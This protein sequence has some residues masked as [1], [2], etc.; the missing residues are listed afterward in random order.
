[1]NHKNTNLLNSSFDEAVD[2]FNS[3]VDG[4]CSDIDEI[5]ATLKAIEHV[6]A[7]DKGL[8]KEYERRKRDE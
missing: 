4:K 2:I 6:R 1:M 7:I 5:C 8:L 3:T